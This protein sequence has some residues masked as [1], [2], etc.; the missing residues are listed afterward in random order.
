MRF[1][2]DE[3]KNRSNHAKHEMSS[4]RFGTEGHAAR[5]DA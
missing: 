4:G 5:K 1:V 2:W 3:R